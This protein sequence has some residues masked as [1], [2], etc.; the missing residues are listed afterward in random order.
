MDNYNPLV[1]EPYSYIPGRP[2]YMEIKHIA[3]AMNIRAANITNYVA[4]GKFP[5]SDTRIGR[6]PLWKEETVMKYL[7]GR[8]TTL[9]AHFHARMALLG[10]NP[11]YRDPLHHQ[12]TKGTNSKNA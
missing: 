1:K 8:P 12:H 3:E 10:F 2:G 4:E 9:S 5:E 11:S 6:T 7:D